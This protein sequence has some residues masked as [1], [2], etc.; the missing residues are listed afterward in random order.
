MSY[1]YSRNTHVPERDRNLSILQAA[2]LGQL[3]CW[4]YFFVAQ[5]MYKG[6]LGIEVDLHSAHQGNVRVVEVSEN[7]LNL[8]VLQENVLLV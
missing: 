2:L 8:R 4:H 1:I 5:P 7:D 6:Q 3:H